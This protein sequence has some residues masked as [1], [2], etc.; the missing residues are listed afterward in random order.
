MDVTVG[1]TKRVGGA[2]SPKRPTILHQVLFAKRLPTPRRLNYVENED[3]MVSSAQLRSRG[4]FGRNFQQCVRLLAGRGSGFKDAA[5]EFASN[6][7]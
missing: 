5:G 6:H 3:S 4:A 2:E 1:S 7:G